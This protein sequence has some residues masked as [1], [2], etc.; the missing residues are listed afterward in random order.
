[1]TLA[2]RCM[3]ESSCSPAHNVR[4]VERWPVAERVVDPT[5]HGV[6]GRRFEHDFS[7]VRVRAG[8]SA[9]ERGGP[10]EVGTGEEDTPSIGERIERT[11]RGFVCSIGRAT[12]PVIGPLSDMATF[13]SPGASGWRGA[14]FGR[15]RNACTRMHRGWDLHAPTGTPIRAVV[16]GRMTRGNDPGLG[17]FVTLTS[18][19]NPDRAYRYSH[20]SRREAAGPFCVGDQLGATGTTGN[21]D[22]DRPHLHFEVRDQ[23]TSIDPQPFLVEPSQVIEA[24][25]SAATAINHAEPDPCP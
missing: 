8:S 6:A 7:R 23:N 9:N 16:T 24:A 3:A 19:A 4:D 12:A 14:K 25:G 11:V 15:H 20:L 13:Q 17:Q 22:A 5:V 1:M 21:A 2:R 10:G 18:D